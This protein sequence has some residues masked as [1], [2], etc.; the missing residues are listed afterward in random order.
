LRPPRATGQGPGRTAAEPR[1]PLKVGSLCLQSKGLQ[2]LYSSVRFRPQLPNGQ[3]REDGTIPKAKLD[4]FWTGS[5]GKSDYRWLPTSGKV[6]IHQNVAVG[7]RCEMD[8]GS[9]GRGFK[10]LHPPQRK[11]S[12]YQFKLQG[13]CLRISVVVTAGPVPAI[14][15]GLSRRSIDTQTEASIP[16]PSNLPGWPWS[17]SNI[18]A[19]RST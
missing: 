3:G 18:S 1:S 4:L 6:H 11:E 17:F 8:C 2:N 19:K 14:L 13:Y 7:D 5:S 16:G 9:S 15:P 12:K 10:S